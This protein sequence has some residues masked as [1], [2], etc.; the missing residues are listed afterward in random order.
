MASW[1]HPLNED[2]RHCISSIHPGLLEAP[3]PTPGLLLGETSSTQ[4]GSPIP[5]PCKGPFAFLT[6]TKRKKCLTGSLMP[7]SNDEA[8]PLIHNGHTLMAPSPG[9]PILQIQ[10]KYGTACSKSHG[11][12]ESIQAW[13]HLCSGGNTEEVYD[14]LVGDAVCHNIFHGYNTTIIAYGQMGSGK[15]FTMGG[16]HDAEMANFMDLSPRSHISVKKLEMFAARS[17][18]VDQAIFEDKEGD[19]IIPHA[20]HDLFKA[21]QHH[22]LANNPSYISGNYNNWLCILLV[23]GVDSPVDWSSVIMEMMVWWWREDCLLWLPSHPMKW[24]SWWIWQLK[25]T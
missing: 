15:T 3:P 19:C 12:A 5:P 11:R 4:P 16:H 2:K 13:C 10:P 7:Q 9:W 1:I 22:E 23:D 17:E 18:E 14:R 8:M 25:D 24:E 6:L 20:I 21:K